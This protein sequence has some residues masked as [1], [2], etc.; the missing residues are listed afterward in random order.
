MAWRAMKHPIDKGNNFAERVFLSS[1]AAWGTF[2][3]YMFD[4]QPTKISNVMMEE[5]GK[6][7]VVVSW[8]TNHYTLNNKVNYGKDL[9]Y[10]NEIWSKDWAKH[11]VVKIT[12]LEPG[13]KYYFEVMSQN[14]NYT[15]DAFY[16]FETLQN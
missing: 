2:H 12:G 8:D 3:A 15:Y 13:Q 5:L 16:S 7:Y 14:K 6:D 4:D 11:H 1:K 10:G 9:M